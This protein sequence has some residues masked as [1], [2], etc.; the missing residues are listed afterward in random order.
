VNDELQTKTLDELH[1]DIEAALFAAQD[2]AHAGGTRE[3]A[4]VV[5]KLEEALL[6]SKRAIGNEQAAPELTGADPS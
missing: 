1:D 3:R 2:L 5:T 4:I 6:W